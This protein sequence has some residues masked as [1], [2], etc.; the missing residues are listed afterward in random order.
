MTKEVTCNV[1]THGGK[2]CNNKAKQTLDKVK[3][4]GKHINALKG[5]NDSEKK[6]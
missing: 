1:I 4:C 3:L 5:K 6:K 2:K